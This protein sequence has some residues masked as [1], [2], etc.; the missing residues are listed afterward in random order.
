[1]RCSSFLN[2]ALS[3]SHL[4]LSPNS[5]Y[6][7]RRPE[8]PTSTGGPAPPHPKLPATL[9]P[10]LVEVG[11]SILSSCN[12]ATKELQQGERFAS[13]VEDAGTVDVRCYHMR[14]VLLE[15][16]FFFAT[17]GVWFCWNHRQICKFAT[18][19]FLVCWNELDFLLHPCFS[20]FAGAQF[21]VFISQVLLPLSSCFAGS[22]AFFCYN[23]VGGS[24]IVSSWLEPATR[25]AA[26]GDFCFKGDGT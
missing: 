8:S 19:N 13:R 23:Q 12:R 9:Q 25:I 26:T 22:N 10:E 5:I 4:A 14:L 16:I 20:T 1:M 3:I 2:Q 24:C 11:T 6:Q 7:P 18:T 15:P 21:P 17:M